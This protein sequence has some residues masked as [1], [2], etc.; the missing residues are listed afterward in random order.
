MLGDF[1]PGDGSS[2]IG[3][4]AI[5]NEKLYFG[6]R[7]YNLWEYDGIHKPTLKWEYTKGYSWGNYFAFKNKLIIKLYDEDEYRLLVYDFKGLPEFLTPL[8]R[9]F[10]RTSHDENILAVNSGKLYY[11]SGNKIW[12]YDGI[13]TA[14]PLEDNKYSLKDPQDLASFQNKLYFS[15]ME[16]TVGRELFVLNQPDTVLFIQTCGKYDFNG[17]ELTSSGIYFDTI[18]SIT[19]NDSIIR[20][21]LLSG[22]KTNR[23][24]DNAC[25]S[26]V[27]HGN[28]YLWTSSGIYSDTIPS[29]EGCDSII[30]VNLTI[31]HGTSS[32]TAISVC[33]GF[34]SPGGQLWLTSGTYTDTTPNAAGCDSIITIELK[35]DHVDNSVTRDMAI[36]TSLDESAAHQWI[37]CDDGNKPIDGD[38][39]SIFT[40]HKDGH[41]AVIV[42]NGACVD[43]SGIY[44]VLATGFTE[45]SGNLISVYPNP[46]SGRF[47]IDLGRVCS[48]SIIL[49]SLEDGRLIRKETMRNTRKI[50][51][52]LDEPPGVYKV[53]VTGDGN[54][55]IF[56]VVKL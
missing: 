39:N 42:T 48:E 21:N 50:N 7:Y 35:V 8:D 13:H 23:I 12:I 54:I 20:L 43:T 34:T 28:R 37:D 16:E 49:I 26:Y 27:S 38:T 44:E 2:T 25:D 51:L 55:R 18:P 33:N 11:K 5:V 6:T 22:S 56:K 3:R 14:Y 24:Y 32:D 4:P 1:T 10:N 40:A 46:T 41:Y 29:I 17:T 52:E 30:T 47:T 31:S 9:N 15:A 45:P 19:G 36:L 53:S